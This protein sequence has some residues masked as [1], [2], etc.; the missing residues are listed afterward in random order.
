METSS[1]PVSVVISFHPAPG[2]QDA[3]VQ[4][5]HDIS[6]AAQDFRGHLGA[7]VYPPAEVQNGDLVIA[8][9]FANADDLS[10]WERSDV[11]RDWLA[12]L[13]QLVEGEATTH[14]VSG[15]EG[16]FSH[17]PG[18]PVI[19]PPRWKTAVIIALALYPMSLLLNWLLNPHLMDLNIFIRVL[20]NTAIIV[21]Y[22]AW[23]GV[24]Y[25]TRWLKGWLRRTS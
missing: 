16:I 25:L 21:P 14:S 4:W 22:M 1:L 10:A 13:D 23:I 7:H 9:S 19:P 11:R 8:F 2:K 17:K 12:K 15:F 3:L 5:A 24:P 6:T 20:I 18:Q